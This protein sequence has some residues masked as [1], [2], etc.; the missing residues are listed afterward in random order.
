[1][2]KVNYAVIAAIQT[3]T[4]E[5]RRENSKGKYTEATCQMFLSSFLSLSFYAHNT[6]MHMHIY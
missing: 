5:V 4:E 6:H 3:H 2:Y 1:M